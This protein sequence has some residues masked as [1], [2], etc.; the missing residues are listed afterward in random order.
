MLQVRVD[1]G[2]EIRVIA[3]D[4][5]DHGRI[6]PGQVLKV[7]RLDVL[8]REPL[9]AAV[10]EGDDLDGPFVH[11]QLAELLQAVRPVARDD[12]KP[13]PVRVTRRGGRHHE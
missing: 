7:L 3:I 11:H 5:F 1:P 10:V 8:R 13:A 6:H 2:H 9:L 12:P 4:P